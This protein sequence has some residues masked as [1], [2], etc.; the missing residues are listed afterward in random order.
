MMTVLDMS[1]NINNQSA[2]LPNLNRTNGSLNGT[3]KNIQGSPALNRPNS[4]MLGSKKYLKESFS[5]PPIVIVGI[6]VVK[7]TTSE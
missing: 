7:H 5:K 4:N 2:L 6:T 3:A 1:R